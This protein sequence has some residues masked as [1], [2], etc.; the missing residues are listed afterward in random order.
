M[1]PAFQIAPADEVPEGARVCHYDEL[2]ESAKQ[3]LPALAGTSAET[4]ADP[5]LASTAETCDLVKFTDYYRV[6]RL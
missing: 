3:R 5:A 2:D 4:T 1:P 6:E